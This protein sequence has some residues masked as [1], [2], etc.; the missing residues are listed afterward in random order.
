MSRAPATCWRS[1]GPGFMVGLRPVPGT[2]VCGPQL[3][4]LPVPP[5]DR[6]RAPDPRPPGPLWP[7]A[8]SWSRTASTGGSTAR[9][10]Y[11]EIHGSSSWIPRVS[12]WEDA[13]FK[14]KRHKKKAGRAVPGPALVHDRDVRPVC[15]CL[16]SA[17][18]GTFSLGQGLSARLLRPGTSWDLRSSR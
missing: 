12:R 5:I 2:P 10:G 17:L 13:E 9:P 16:A 6:R 14:L 11:G 3:G 15:H 7:P 8:L 4:P 1:T 18:Q